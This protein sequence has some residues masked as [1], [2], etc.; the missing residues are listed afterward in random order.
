MTVLP[1]KSE[2]PSLSPSSI[3]ATATQGSEKAPALGYSRWLCI[4]SCAEGLRD[5]AG[6]GVSKHCRR[7]HKYEEENTGKFA[8][9]C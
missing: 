2:R 8:F 1:L 3:G 4:S 6:A 5:R 7:A 9:H